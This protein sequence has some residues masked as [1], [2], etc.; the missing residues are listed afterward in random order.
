VGVTTFQLS[1][2]ELGTAFDAIDYAVCCMEDTLV[3]CIGTQDYSEEDLGEMRE[4]LAKWRQLL[5]RLGRDVL[6][7]FN[8]VTTEE[9]KR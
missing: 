1:V 7:D 5:A 2:I 3:G 6:D 9:E 4:Q 8:G